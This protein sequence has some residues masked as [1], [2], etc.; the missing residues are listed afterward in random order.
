[1]REPE[2]EREGIERVLSNDDT[3]ITIDSEY[4]EVSKQ[5]LYM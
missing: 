4:G 2:T 3:L 5:N 1:M